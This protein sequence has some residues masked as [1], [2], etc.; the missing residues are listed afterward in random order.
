MLT[1]PY[2]GNESFRMAII[3]YGTPMFKKYDSRLKKDV[4]QLL[5]QLIKRFDYKLEGAKQI[6]F[7]ALDKNL[8]GKF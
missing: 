1:V 3:D 2:I 5:N 7:Y 4:T 6:T 8:P